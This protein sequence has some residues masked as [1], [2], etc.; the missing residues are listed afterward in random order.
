MYGSR[1]DH[2]QSSSWG[3]GFFVPFYGLPFTRA[4]ALTGFLVWLGWRFRIAE[5]RTIAK[6]SVLTLGL[7]SAVCLLVV[8]GWG[9]RSYFMVGFEHC[10]VLTLVGSL[11]TF[12]SHP[13]VAE[14]IASTRPDGQLVTTRY[15]DIAS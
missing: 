8:K 10:V 1:L 4:L 7:L 15:H 9:D 11:S 2:Y 5:I 6:A 12:A 14:Y 13:P 3:I